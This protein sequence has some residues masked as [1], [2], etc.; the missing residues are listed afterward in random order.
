MLLPRFVSAA[1]VAAFALVSAVQA[2][3]WPAQWAGLTRTA[4]PEPASAVDRP[5]WDEYGLEA[6]ERAEYGSGAQRRVVVAYRLKDPTGAYAAFQWQRLEQSRPVP[7]LDLGARVN[8]V[9]V[10]ALGN[11]VLRL[12]GPPLEAQA[13]TDAAAALPQ[14]RRTSLPG[15]LRLLPP[16]GRVINSER[17]ILGP[18]SLERFGKGLP[19]DAAAFQFGTEAQVAA[20][21]DGGTSVAVFSYPTPSIARQRLAAFQKLEGVQARRTSTYVV[22]SPRAGDAALAQSL[23]EQVKVQQSVTLSE[24]TPQAFATTMDQ[25]LSIF[26]FAGFMVLITA[27]GGLAFG[28]GRFYLRRWTGRENEESMTV[29]HLNE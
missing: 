24:P 1:L 2:E 18:V 12:D 26:Y 20:Y 5:L 11:Y 16:Q 25:L 19:A 21:G 17:Y 14:F 6:S 4:G 8:D 27:V 9:T 29:L 15:L 7:G 3:I 10:A 23:V 28:V 22:V 13:L